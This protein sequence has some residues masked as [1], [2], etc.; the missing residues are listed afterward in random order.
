MAWIQPFVPTKVES[1]I[2]LVGKYKSGSQSHLVV[3]RLGNR[4]LEAMHDETV[5]MVFTAVL[6]NNKHGLPTLIP[7]LVFF[8]LFFFDKSA[9]EMDFGGLDISTD[10]LLVAEIKQTVPI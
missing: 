6:I 3:I 10:L 7:P 5:V 9:S 1:L 8:T 2:M 4:V